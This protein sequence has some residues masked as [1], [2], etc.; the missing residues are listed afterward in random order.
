MPHH[1][2]KRTNIC[3]S[4]S[5][6]RSLIGFRWRHRGTTGR[7]VGTLPL[8]QLRTTQQ[9]AFG[10]MSETPQPCRNVTGRICRLFC[11]QS[12]ARHGATQSIDS[13]TVKQIRIRKP[14]RIERRM[15]LLTKLISHPA[16]VWTVVR[17]CIPVP[18]HRTHGLVYWTIGT[19]PWNGNQVV[20]EFSD[21]LDINLVGARSRVEIP[22][23]TIDLRRRECLV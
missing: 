5:H 2:E 1:F 13:I 12:K 14:C 23:V 16:L 18:D 21:Q 6:G 17:Y 20:A 11:V 4:P 8:R 19:C 15:H 22:H 10:E 9:N 7:G 3:Q